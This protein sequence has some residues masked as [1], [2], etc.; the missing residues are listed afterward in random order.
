MLPLS[1]VLS[2]FC[3]VCL[4]TPL[5]AYQGCD[6]ACFPA[7]YS[8]GKELSGLRKLAAKFFN[9]QSNMILFFLAFWFSCTSHC[10]T[11]KLFFLFH[12]IWVALFWSPA[13]DKDNASF[14][15][16][17]LA[18]TCLTYEAV[19]INTSRTTTPSF[20]GANSTNAKPPEEPLTFPTNLITSCWLNETKSCHTSAQVA[21]DATLL[22]S[23]FDPGFALEFDGFLPFTSAASSLLWHFDSRSPETCLSSMVYWAA[24]TS[25]NASSA[26]TSSA[27]PKPIE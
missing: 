27:N 2:P 13:T 15:L 11:K 7:I 3:S 8:K 4:Q 18:T 19:H 5:K 17:N 26:R 24:P 20:L 6:S 21:L 12:D 23:N 22:T 1:L 16:S 14:M 25:S 10:R 9:H